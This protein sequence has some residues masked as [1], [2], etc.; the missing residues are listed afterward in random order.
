MLGIWTKGL[1]YVDH[2]VISGL[3]LDS[4]YDARKRLLR[5]TQV[6][7]PST[8]LV[9]RLIPSAASIRPGDRVIASR[10]CPGLSSPCLL[11]CTKSL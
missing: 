10:A 1:K 2:H 11:A 7:S 3:Q 8:S 5:K 6:R 4:A 9:T